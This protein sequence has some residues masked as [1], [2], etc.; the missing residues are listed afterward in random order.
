MREDCV[1][2]LAGIDS[3]SVRRHDEVRLSEEVHLARVR[4]VA[5]E[6]RFLE[7]A[8]ERERREGHRAHARRHAA[9]VEIREDVGAKELAQVFVEPGLDRGRN[10]SGPRSRSQ[11]KAR[12][13]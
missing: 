3:E 1:L 9:G 8:P 4:A 6:L 2:D 10:R 11:W 12:A 13:V 7:R 5:L